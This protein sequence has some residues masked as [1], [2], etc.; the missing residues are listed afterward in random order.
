MPFWRGKFIQ[1]QVPDAGLWDLAAVYGRTGAASLAAL[2]G[3]IGV[4]FLS[5]AQ[6]LALCAG[7]DHDDLNILAGMA[8]MP[9][10]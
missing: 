2:A 6:G 10:S 8:A 1:D 4:C 5:K 9:L 3:Q 7:V